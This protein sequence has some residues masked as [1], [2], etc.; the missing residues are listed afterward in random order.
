MQDMLIL[1]GDGVILA[2]LR[3][4][5]AVTNVSISKRMMSLHFYPIA[6]S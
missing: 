1:E 5:R 2:G 4:F 6:K 3:M